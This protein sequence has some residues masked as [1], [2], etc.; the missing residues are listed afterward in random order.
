MLFRSS[1]LYPHSL[2]YPP[3]PPPLACLL[4]VW[5][6]VN[7]I[8]VGM[9]V[10][11]FYALK[12][13]GVGMFTILKNLSNFITI[14]GDWYFFNR[15]YNLQV[16]SCLFL[17]VASALFGGYTD[18][19]CTWVGYSWQLV[20]CFFTS[21][22]ALYL[23]GAMTR[24][25]P[26]TS[27][28]ERMTEF[29]MVYYNNLLSIFP[30]IALMFYFGEFGRL[31]AEPAL[32][33]PEFLLVA[34]AGGLLG[35]GISFASLWFVSR[36][37]ATIYSLTGSLNKVIVAVAGLLLFHEANSPRNQMSIG[38]GLLAGVVFVLAKSSP[39]K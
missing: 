35:F 36:T 15:T 28:K 2:P 26:F 39:L 31:L 3:P 22:Y 20:N 5:A 37:T 33:N 10:T 9:I 4:Q 19:K 1:T 18:L 29:S 23:S 7:L 34:V 24:V 38:V 21:A 11:S 32:Y 27:D 30:I 14:T 13:I 8:F 17:M 16:W 25:I 12:L 6:P